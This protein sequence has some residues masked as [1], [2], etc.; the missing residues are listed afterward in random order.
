MSWRQQRGGEFIAMKKVLIVEDNRL[1]S[2]LIEE[3][4]SAMGYHVIAKMDTPLEALLQI[5]RLEPH[6]VLLNIS[7]TGG[8]DDIE[9]AERI[10]EAYGVPVI[11]MTTHMDGAIRHRALEVASGRLLD[12]PLDE[13]ELQRHLEGICGVPDI[14]RTP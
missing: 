1:L 10:Q 8:H 7:R 13:L 12:K 2:M 14:R 4:V 6:A 11:F 3:T 9:V 5:K